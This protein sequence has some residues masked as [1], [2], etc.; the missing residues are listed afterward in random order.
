MRVRRSSS[1]PSETRPA[2]RR[3]ATVSAIRRTPA[4]STA[5]ASVFRPGWSPSRIWSIARPVSHGIA[6]VIVRATTARRPD[7][8]RPQR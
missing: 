2:M 3:R 5:N 7:Q 6:A 4:P 1:T 8:M